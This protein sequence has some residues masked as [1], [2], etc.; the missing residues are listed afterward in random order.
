MYA[1]RSYY[2]ITIASDDLVNSSYEL[3]LHGN[4]TTLGAEDAPAPAAILLSQNYPNP[5]SL[6]TSAQTVYAFTL[7]ARMAVTMSLY[8]LQGRE[9]LRVADGEYAAGRHELRRITSYN[10]CYTK[11][12]RTAV[13]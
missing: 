5:V 2:V 10:V 7:P 13:L 6:A 11:L 4:A 9:V 3:Q 8:D 1:I 12:L